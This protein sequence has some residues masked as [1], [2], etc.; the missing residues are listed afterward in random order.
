MA[1]KEDQ[2]L[3]IPDFIEVLGLVLLGAGTFLG[4]NYFFGGNLAVAIPTTLVIILLM[5]GLVY[6]LKILKRA[7]RNQETKKIGEVLIFILLFIPIALGS[8]IFFTHF[9]NI[10]FVAKDNIKTELVGDA[11]KISLIFKNYEKHVEDDVLVNYEADL[12]TDYNAGKIDSEEAVKDKLKIQKGILLPPEFYLAQ[13]HADSA[14]ATL[15]GEIKAWNPI[16]IPYTVDEIPKRVE[17]EQE[18]FANELLGLEKLEEKPFIFDFDK[19]IVLE[20]ITKFNSKNI[21]WIY[22][23]IAFL[24]IYIMI[25]W[26][27]IATSRSAKVN[28]KRVKRRKTIG[29][30][31]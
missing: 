1:K 19:E 17:I 5:A 23:I 26:P 14:N 18:W 9:L 3:G 12:Y 20:R 13:E 2:N 30:E 21:N 24:F 6:V 16:T 7:E 8:F 29:G 25:L 28:V 4:S 22:T 31:L 27:Y 10:E 15:V 11:N